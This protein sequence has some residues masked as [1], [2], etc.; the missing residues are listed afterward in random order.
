[1]ERP[2]RDKVAGA[3]DLVALAYTCKRLHKL[4]LEGAS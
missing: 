2:G 4:K 1:M 3:W